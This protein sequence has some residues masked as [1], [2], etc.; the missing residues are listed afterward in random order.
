[1]TWPQAEAECVSYGGH[2]TSIRNKTLNNFI[3]NLPNIKCASS[4]WTGGNFDRTVA[5]KW[6]WVDSTPWSYTNWA[7]GQPASSNCMIFGSQSQATWKTAACPSQRPFVCEFA[8]VATSDCPDCPTAK[9][10]PVCEA[11]PLCDDGWTYLAA[12]KTCYK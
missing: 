11:Q 12:T 10:C 3:F 1:I 2:L 9:Q 6:A 7:T 8:G 5:G 4:Y